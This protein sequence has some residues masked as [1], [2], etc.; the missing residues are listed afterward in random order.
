MPKSRYDAPQL[1]ST[2]GDQFGCQRG[3]SSPR[4]S[5]HALLQPC[6][7]SLLSIL[8][9]SPTWC[10]SHL[11]LIC[12]LFDPCCNLLQEA[13]VRE[14]VENRTD[15][16]SSFKITYYQGRYD[17]SFCSIFPVGDLTCAVPDAEACPNAGVRDKVIGCSAHA[18]EAPKSSVLC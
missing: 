18:A 6:S 2:P 14:W 15:F 7:H 12:Q 1:H 16:P 13:F 5:Q 17:P 9:Y 3:C 10:R 4:T 11:Q 8:H